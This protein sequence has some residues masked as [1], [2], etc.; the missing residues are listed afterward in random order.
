MAI[1]PAHKAITIIISMAI[2]YK[3]DVPLGLDQFIALY[4]S[5]TLGARRPLDDLTIAAQMQQY[6]NLQITAWDNDL[7]V[8]ISR[9][10]TDFGYICYLAD[11]A[12]RDSHQK[13]GIGLELIR[14]TRAA[15][16]PR[17][18]IVLI[19]APQAVDYYPKIGFTRH[20]SAWILKAGEP[21]PTNN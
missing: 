13:Q 15:L 21:L 14:L 4:Q 8:G 12:I 20:E 2:T 16:G 6:G 18:N 17:A 7:L 5:C 3:R 9:S 1:A 19:A 11:L 10:M